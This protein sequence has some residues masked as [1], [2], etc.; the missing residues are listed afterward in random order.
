MTAY[1]EVL[2]EGASDI[3][4]VEELLSRHF[5][6][7][8]NVHF[9]VHPHHGKG[10]LPTNFLKK[11]ELWH[12]GLLDQ[13]P[14]KLK[15]FAT[16]LPK[17]ALVLV[18]IDVDRDDCRELLRQLQDM[19][20]QLHRRPARVL[21]RLAIEETESWFLA[22]QDALRQGLPRVRLKQ[23]QDI[24]PDAVVGAWELL[25][26][27]LGRDPHTV[28]GGDKREWAEAIAPYLNFQQPASPSLRKLVDGIKKYLDEVSP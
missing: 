19:L 8:K 9:R 28:T 16:Y 2:A 13:L 18:L 27:A 3:P 21:F 22:D 23:L 1:I 20:A 26:K 6:L 15:G 12:R 5:D 25:A 24:S 14:A 7:T 11:P 4:V 17:D 10:T